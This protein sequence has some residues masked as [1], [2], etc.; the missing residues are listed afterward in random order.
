MANVVHK[1]EPLTDKTYYTRF[2]IFEANDIP[3]TFTP[4]GTEHGFMVNDF[5]KDVVDIM[6]AFIDNTPKSPR[7]RSLSI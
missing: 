5:G 7:K 4:N 2:R 3:G 1:H 6:Q